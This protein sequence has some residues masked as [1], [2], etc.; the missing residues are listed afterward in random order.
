VE[1]DSAENAE[2]ILRRL[3]VSR[4]FP[5]Y[6]KTYG[7]N[8]RTN[9][10][11]RARA[12]ARDREGRPAF[13]HSSLFHRRNVATLIPGKA[14]ADRAISA[15]TNVFLRKDARRRSRRLWRFPEA[16]GNRSGN[17]DVY[18]RLIEAKVNRTARNAMVNI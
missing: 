3:E 7:Y 6:G 8:Q 9:I 13:I 12:G 15:I 14:P 5:A 18:S 16:G 2:R 4:L 11:F 17:A 10:P 1:T